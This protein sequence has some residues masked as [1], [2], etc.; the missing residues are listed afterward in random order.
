M[1]DLRPARTVRVTITDRGAMLLDL[2]GRGR[3]YVLTPSGA[4]WWRHLTDGATARE[5]ADKVADLF[6]AAPEEVRADMTTLA[7]QL[8]ARR[9]LQAPRL[10]GW[11]R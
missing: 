2:R 5:A 10:K 3:W 11:H 4:L 8:V 1:A 6:G 7:A 9:L